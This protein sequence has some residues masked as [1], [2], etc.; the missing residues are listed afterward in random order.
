M[1]GGLVTEL[2]EVMSYVECVLISGG[3]L[4]KG[5][6]EAVAAVNAKIAIDETKG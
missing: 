4:L 2:L 1:R 6:G 3:P 5:C